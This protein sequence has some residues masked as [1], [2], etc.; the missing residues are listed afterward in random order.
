MGSCRIVTKGKILS[1]HI[2][3][4]RSSFLKICA[5]RGVKVAEGKNIIGVD[6]GKL[7]VEGEE[8]IEFDECLWC[9]QAS[10]SSW[11][12]DTGLETGCKSIHTVV[13]CCCQLLFLCNCTVLLSAD[14][15][16]FLLVD[17]YLRCQN[18]NEG[19]FSAGDVATSM[20]DPRPKA[21][22]FAVRQ[23]IGLP[24]STQLLS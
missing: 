1:S 5:N 3:Y 15:Q 11:I 6:V 20:S 4:M 22:V 8:A 19:I 23:V 14:E 24:H 18:A 9:T 21:G 7:T 12:K 2:P 17:E 13:E 16:G 10:A